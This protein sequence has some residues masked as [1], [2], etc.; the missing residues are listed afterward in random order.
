MIRFAAFTDVHFD[1]V[2]DGDSRIDEFVKRISNEPLDFI[3]SLGDLCYPIE[4]NKK[5]ITKLNRI[6]IP[7]YYVIGNHD[8]DCYSQET[9]MDFLNLNTLNYSFI[10]ENT[11]FIVLNSCYMKQNDIDY[12][13]YKKNFE[14]ESDVYPVVSKV[15][16]KWL[17][18][19]MNDEN[20]N[21]V[22]FS[23]HSLANDF[24]KR[25]VANRQVI[26]NIIS[27]KKTIMSINGHDHGTDCKVIS[28]V[29]YYT[30][31]S[32]SYI[33]HGLREVYPYSNLIHKEYPY[34]KD[35]I[36]YKEALYCIVEINDDKVKIKG[37]KSEYQC[38]TPED[39]GI[40]DRKWNGVSIEAK[41]L[42]FQQ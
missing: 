10:I 37:M 39:V 22:I 17:Q 16:I 7:I 1:H 11:K 19:E 40:C 24:N 2:F 41:V 34:L 5:I 8:S 9:V 38:T 29:P 12:P 33:W 21:Y 6:N 13:Y 31:N 4:E 28:G 14:K 35:M 30:L 42:D 3:I 27:S 32:M 23:H 36:L 20:L 18:R 15:Q 26:Q 25:G